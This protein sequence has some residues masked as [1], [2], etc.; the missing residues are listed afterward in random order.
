MPELWLRKIFPGVGNSNSKIYE[1]T[2]LLELPEIVQIFINAI[3]STDTKL[4]LIKT[5]MISFVTHRSSRDINWNK[6]K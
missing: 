2:E 3:W 4:G 6:S 1:R 5:L